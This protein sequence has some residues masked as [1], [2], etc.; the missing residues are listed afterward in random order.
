MFYLKIKHFEG[1]GKCKCL[2]QTTGQIKDTEHL[3][4]GSNIVDLTKLLGEGVVLDFK[5]SLAN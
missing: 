5:F 4:C 2:V 1:K 3:P